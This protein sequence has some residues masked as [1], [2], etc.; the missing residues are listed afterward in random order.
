MLQKKEIESYTDCKNV[1]LFPE[2]FQKIS[3]LGGQTSGLFVKEL[4]EF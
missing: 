1:L 3:F 4:N 2:C